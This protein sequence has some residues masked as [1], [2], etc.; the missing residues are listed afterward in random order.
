MEILGFALT[1]A[2]TG[3][4]TFEEWQDFVQ[5][6]FDLLRDPDKPHSKNS[7]TAPVVSKLGTCQNHAFFKTGPSHLFAP[8]I[9]SIPLWVQTHKLLM[10]QER[11]IRRGLAPSDE[12]DFP[13][14]IKGLPLISRWWGARRRRCQV[15]SRLLGREHGRSPAHPKPMA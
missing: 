6:A 8:E 12:P 13:C 11:F 9:T 5:Q 10:S 1:Q 4:V 15:A 3:N 7:R 14:E 2:A